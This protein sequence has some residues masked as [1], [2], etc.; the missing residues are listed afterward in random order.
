MTRPSASK[1][2]VPTLLMIKSSTLLGRVT[3]V[4]S[5]IMPWAIWMSDLTSIFQAN[6][7]L[8]GSRRVFLTSDSK[9]AFWYFRSS[10]KGSWV[11]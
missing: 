8:V 9:V 2:S 11:R 6:L 1:V 10:M 5:D 7:S 3:S 4:G